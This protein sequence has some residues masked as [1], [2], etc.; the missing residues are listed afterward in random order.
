[1][2]DPGEKIS[3]TMKREFM[4]EALNSNEISDEELTEF[5]SKLS[6][7]FSEGVEVI[8]NFLFII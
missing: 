3:N 2:C 1:M 8:K 6:T 7:F 4:E 5:K